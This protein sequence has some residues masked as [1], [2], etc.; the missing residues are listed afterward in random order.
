MRHNQIFF[1]AGC[2]AMLLQSAC[3]DQPEY[4]EPVLPIQEEV[5]LKMAGKWAVVSQDAL[6]VVTN[7]KQI[8]TYEAGWKAYRSQ[9][10]DWMGHN[11][12]S[13]VVKGN[14]ITETCG[15]LTYVSAVESLNETELQA[16]VS[17]TNNQQQGGSHRYVYRKVKQSY[18]KDLLGLWEGKLATPGIPDSTDHRWQ[19]NADGTYQV[20][21]HDKEQEEW[22]VDPAQNGQYIVDGNWL[23]MRRVAANQ[24]ENR[25]CWDITV[26][27]DNMYWIALRADSTG[28]RHEEQMQLA[29]IN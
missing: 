13:C 29:K 5:E 19:F 21:F 9:A 11:S 1:I 27:N 4:I 18:E 3:N 26:E 16:T 25:T 15:A 2:F 7:E 20:F 12:Y 24:P 10:I 28:I 22:V 23:A 17:L 14:N 8:V 6:P